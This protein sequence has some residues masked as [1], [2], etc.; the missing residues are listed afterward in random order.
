MR[1]V[2]DRSCRFYVLQYRS[3]R[4]SVA[5]RAHPR[6][7]LGIECNFVSPWRR[8]SALVLI[9]RGHFLLSF[10]PGTLIIELV[11]TELLEIIKL[12]GQVP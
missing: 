8:K 4:F 10:K 11:F 6:L 12:K 2:D 5:E 3:A 1:A 9:E 7:G